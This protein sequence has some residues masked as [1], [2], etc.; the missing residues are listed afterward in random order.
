MKVVLK[1]N[2]TINMDKR[3]TVLYIFAHGTLTIPLQLSKQH[4]N[5]WCNSMVSFPFLLIKLCG[6]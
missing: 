4:L 6:V 5:K 1:R 2:I 3:I